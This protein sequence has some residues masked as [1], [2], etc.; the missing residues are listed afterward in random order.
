VLPAHGERESMRPSRAAQEPSC[1]GAN[2]RARMRRTTQLG[3][4]RRPPVSRAG[5]DAEALRA[6]VLIAWLRRTRMHAIS[7][8]GHGKLGALRPSNGRTKLAEHVPGARIPTRTQPDFPTAPNCPRVPVSST[9]DDRSLHVY[10]P[11]SGR[12]SL[13][14]RAASVPGGRGDQCCGWLAFKFVVDTWCLELL[15]A[16]CGGSWPAQRL[17]LEVGPGS[18]WRFES[19]SPWL[20]RRHASLN[21]KEAA[22][23]FGASLESAGPVSGRLGPL[24]LSGSEI[25][26]TRVRPGPLRRS[27]SS[28]SLAAR[29]Q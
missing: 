25:S 27:S 28:E 13:R 15:S 6:S 8:C 16:C 1:C 18:Q 23:N 12:I 22:G 7:Q 5:R 14:G 4:T 17:Y 21:L 20:E 10:D 19:S 26:S 3:S 9:F 24:A 2:E 29:S 11:R